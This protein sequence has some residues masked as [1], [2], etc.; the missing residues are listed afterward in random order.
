MALAPVSEDYSMPMQLVFEDDWVIPI[1]L[2][3]RLH[4][5]LDVQRARA[6]RSEMVDALVQ[7][8]STCFANSLTECL[9]TDLRLPSQSQLGYA[10]DIA[11]ELGVAIP[12]DALR[13]RGAMGEFINRFADSFNQRRARYQPTR[14]PDA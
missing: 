12:A 1:P 6:S 7:R 9:D 11:R 14:L 3:A 2:D 5:A 13:Y 10:M 4:E 8:L